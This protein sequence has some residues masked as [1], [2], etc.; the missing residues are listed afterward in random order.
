MVQA[1][2]I[3]PNQWSRE[4]CPD[5][6]INNISSK[7]S[8]MKGL[9][10]I[11]RAKKYL[12]SSSRQSRIRRVRMSS[13][14]K[15]WCKGSGSNST[16]I[17]STSKSMASSGYWAI[18]CVKIATAKSFR[19]RLRTLSSERPTC[20][21]RT[22]SSLDRT[23]LN[24]P[25]QRFSLFTR[26]S[27]EW[28]ISQDSSTMAGISM[29]PLMLAWWMRGIKLKHWSQIMACYSRHTFKL[30]SLRDQIWSPRCS[31]WSRLNMDLASRL[32]KRR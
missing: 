16:Q 12:S 9:P 8:R 23:T 6:P 28:R 14:C 1:T 17:T 13:R 2:L 31:N 22:S 24:C 11:Q 7:W 25:V 15:L 21:W 26:T 10:T 32:T 29:M 4:L 27:L 5:L 19:S 3:K 30:S 18:V 20:P